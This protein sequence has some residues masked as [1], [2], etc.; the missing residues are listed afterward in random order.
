[1]E[2]KQIIL[3][4]RS[5]NTIDNCAYHVAIERQRVKT[6]LLVD[7]IYE[8]ISFRNSRFKQSEIL[9]FSSFFFK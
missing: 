9:T 4:S 7:K 2:T 3:W 1:M 8:K 5:L 6:N